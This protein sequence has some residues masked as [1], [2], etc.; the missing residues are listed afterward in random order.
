[1]APEESEFKS[2]GVSIPAGLGDSCLQLR[3]FKE[4]DFGLKFLTFLTSITSGNLEIL[5]FLFHI[6]VNQQESVGTYL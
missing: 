5:P 1:M 2:N 4:H 6:K 3:S